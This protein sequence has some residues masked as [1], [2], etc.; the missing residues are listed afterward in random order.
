VKFY[1]ILVIEYCHP[2]GRLLD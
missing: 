1:I 2:S